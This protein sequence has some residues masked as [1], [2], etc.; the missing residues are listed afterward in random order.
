MRVVRFDTLVYM[1]AANAQG[2][3]TLVRQIVGVVNYC[4]KDNGKLADASVR[5]EK[6]RFA[7]VDANIKAFNEGQKAK[8][9]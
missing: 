2:L 4:Y 1:Q 3:K 6:N 9:A 7:E 8:H 5:I